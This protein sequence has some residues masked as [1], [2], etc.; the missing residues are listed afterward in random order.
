MPFCKR[1]NTH[2]RL[3]QKSQAAFPG[4]LKKFCFTSMI[5]DSTQPETSPLLMPETPL[6]LIHVTHWICQFLTSLLT[7]KTSPWNNIWSSKHFGSPVFICSVQLTSIKHLLYTNNCAQLAKTAK[8]M[9]LSSTIPVSVELS[10]SEWREAVFIMFKPTYKPCSSKLHLKR[11]YWQVVMRI[12]PWVKTPN[13]CEHE[14][15]LFSLFELL[16]HAW[17]TFE[18]N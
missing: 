7:C 1:R 4:S 8:Y 14:T 11:W 16:L 13:T 2:S 10:A 9:R 6:P 15:C 12:P 3:Q 18:K 5:K 17:S